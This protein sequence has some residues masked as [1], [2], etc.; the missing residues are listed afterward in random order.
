V[1]SYSINGWM[2]GTWVLGQ[3]NYTVFHRLD[4][5]DTP[6]RRWVFI[7]E[8]ERSINDG[9]FAV[10]MVGRRGLLDVPSTRH[11]DAYALGFADGHTELFKIEDG[12]TKA[13]TRRPIPNAPLNPDWKRLS[14]VTTYGQ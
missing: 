1:R 6:S 14:E 13:F 9:W 7:D 8:H 4:E 12:R 5:V 10:D 3:S 11:G 2:G